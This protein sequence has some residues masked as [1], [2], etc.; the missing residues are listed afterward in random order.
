M[1]R[2]LPGPAMA[3][4]SIETSPVV[5]SSNPA[6]MRSRVDLPQPEA[7]IRQTNSPSGMARSTGA[8]AS[9]SPSPT[10]KRL[11]T[12]RTVRM[13]ACPLLT[14]LW[15]PAQ[16]AVADRYDDAVGDEST[17]ADD[18]HA[19]DHEV[20]ARQRA[21]VHHHR[22][23]AGGNAGHFANHDQNPGKSVGDPQAGKDRREGCRQ[24]DLA[25]HGRPRAAEHGSGLEQ[26]GIDRA[27]PENRVEQ[28]RI[29]CTQ[30]D[31]EDRRV[32]SEAEE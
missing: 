13:S 1:P 7:P 11:V 14:V 10:A 25:K 30:E 4:R 12:P 21:A 3:L 31:Q 23:Q 24:H 27:H 28:D 17:G 2:S 8:S 26:F 32:G 20:G 22:A 9:S 29:K 16:E 15:A 6:M 19:G 5:G 18:D